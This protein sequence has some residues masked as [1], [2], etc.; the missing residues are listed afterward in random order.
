[1]VE[2]TDRIRCVVVVPKLVDQELPNYGRRLS[3][4]KAYTWD[5]INKTLES[6]LGEPAERKKRSP[7]TFRTKYSDKSEKSFGFG[8]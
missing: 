6:L 4:L 7:R 3:I 2:I 5:S 1:M 8:T